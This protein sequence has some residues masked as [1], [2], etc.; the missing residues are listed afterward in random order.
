VLADGSGN[1]G[2]ALEIGD[3]DVVGMGVAGL[4]SDHHSNTGSIDMGARRAL[5]DALVEGEGVRGAS[6]QEDVAEPVFAR[7]CPW[8]RRQ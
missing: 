5:D 1:S 2:A 3:G 7:L 4:V 8:R 6:L